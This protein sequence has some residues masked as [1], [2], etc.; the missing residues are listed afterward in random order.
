MEQEIE[1]LKKKIAACAR[2]NS[3]LQEELSEAYRIKVENFNFLSFNFTMANFF[4][5]LWAYYVICF[6]LVFI[7]PAGGFTCC[8]GDKG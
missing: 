5:F 7:G 1:N 2:E 4:F 6:L 8:G 3:N